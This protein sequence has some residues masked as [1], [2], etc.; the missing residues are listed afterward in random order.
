MV[1]ILHLVL[2]YSVRM[3]PCIVISEANDIH[4]IWL[5]QIGNSRKQQTKKM[6][7]EKII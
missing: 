2:Q 3:H 5:Y 6:Y 4:L 7:K 1:W